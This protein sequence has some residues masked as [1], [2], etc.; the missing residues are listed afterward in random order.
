MFT[1]HLNPQ[2]AA[3]CLPSLWRVGRT[4]GRET[5]KGRPNRGPGGNLEFSFPRLRSSSWNGASSSSATCP[6]RSGSTWQ[7]LSNSPPRRSK[8]GFRTD[9]TNAKGSDRT[10]HSSW[11]ATTTLPHRGESPYPSWS[12]TGSPVL[13]VHRTTTRPTDRIPIVITDIRVIHTTTQLTTATTA[14]RT[15]ASLLYR[16]PPRPT[17]S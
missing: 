15:Q 16:P 17:P 4:A 12:G 13:V 6:P 2:R 3:A 5:R 1:S 11:R 7:A 10:S 9:G 8:S 14:A